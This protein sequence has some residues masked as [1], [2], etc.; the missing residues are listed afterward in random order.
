[1]GWSLRELA[2][3]E[4]DGLATTRSTAA[5]V[6]PGRHPNGAA[7]IDHVVVLTPDLDRTFAALEAAGIEL[8]RVRDAGTAERPLRQGF[9]R[10]G[11]VILEVV[12]APD[13]DGPA[14]FWGLVFVVEDIDALAARL[15]EQLGSVKAAVQPGRQIATALGPV[16][17]AGLARSLG[18]QGIAVR[19]EQEFGPALNDALHSPLPTVLHLRVDPEQISVAADAGG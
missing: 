19:D 12:G 15:G 17:F 5:P 2:T 1:M 13:A 9:F 4:L 16:D 18:G 10:L 11:E 14:A 6:E 7:R 8:R 3:T